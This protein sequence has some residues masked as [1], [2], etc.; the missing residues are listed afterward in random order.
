MVVAAAATP[1]P[2][3]AATPPLPAAVATAASAAAALLRRAGPAPALAAAP[4]SSEMLV[5]C[6]RR[7]HET[8]LEYW[9][10][11][12]WQKYAR[13]LSR[14]G[15]SL[16]R[17]PLPAER[18][19]SALPLADALRFRQKQRRYS[20]CQAIFFEHSFGMRRKRQGRSGGQKAPGTWLPERDHAPPATIR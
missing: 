16:L 14:S 3:P 15:L 12:K 6:I 11:F 8:I 7:E 1:T 9:A 5:A 17:R 10:V 19:P 4:E 18:T 13:L 20:H 2:A